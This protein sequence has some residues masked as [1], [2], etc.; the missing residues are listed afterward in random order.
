MK[1]Q[2]DEIV[3]A[4]VTKTRPGQEV[5]LSLEERNQSI[6]ITEVEGLFKSTGVPVNVGDQ[7][8]EVNGTGV[9]NTEE[10]PNGLQDIQKFLKGEWNIWI[11]VKKGVCKDDRDDTCPTV[12]SSSSH[13]SLSSRNQHEEV[14]PTVDSSDSSINQPQV[15]EQ[16]ES[17][18]PQIVVSDS[19][20]SHVAIPG[21]EF[22]TEPLRTESNPERPKK[23]RR[24]SKS[25]DST[26]S[27]RRSKST[28]SSK[29]KSRSKS[30]SRSKSPH[31]SK[32][33]KRSKSPHSAHDAVEKRRSERKS[34]P[35]RKPANREDS[36]SVG[37]YT[38]T[39]RSLSEDDNTPPREGRTCQSGTLLSINE[40][41]TGGS[42]SP[43]TPH[44][45]ISE[46]SETTIKSVTGNKNAITV[47][48]ANGKSISVTPSQLL[49]CISEDGFDNVSAPS[50]YTPMR[51]KSHG[52]NRDKAASENN[53]RSNLVRTQ[54][55]KSLPH[56]LAD[57]EE[58]DEDTKSTS[59]FKSKKNSMDES[60]HSC[61][62]NLIDPGDL[63]K[64]R[65]FTAQ[66]DM[67][68]LTVEVVRKSKGTKGKRW[69]VRVINTNKQVEIK[70]SYNPKRL[71]SVATENLKH[72][73]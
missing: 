68:G 38:E 49:Q 21:G 5:G 4:T 72:F 73:V 47:E 57:E 9:A 55:R 52:N 53:L 8:L 36:E 37:D 32:S 58:S 46:V 14:E 27:R 20:D 30:R 28:D 43:L 3:K 33:R 40:C 51:K 62:T 59:W 42:L 69:D 24:R 64:I 35:T 65:G 10:F 63:M 1:Y 6:Y 13:T 44:K 67:N 17:V 61:M 25:T 26:K 54:G 12:T 48:M 7:L 34:R 18:Q 19:E 15:A 31:S 29:S 23:A 2:V 11:K 22:W 70:S 60:T 41:Q 45:S 50:L 56:F 66:A 71:I 16:P 39:T